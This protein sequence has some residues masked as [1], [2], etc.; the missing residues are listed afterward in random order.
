M[1]ATTGDRTLFLRF[2]VVTL[3]AVLH[4]AHDLSH[5]YSI[6]VSALTGAMVV[7][8]CAALTLGHLLTSRW[9]ARRWL[10]LALGALISASFGLAILVPH[11]ERWDW[12]GL[13]VA[14]GGVVVGFGVAGLWLLVFRLPV[15]IERARLRDME[16]ESLRSEAELSRMRAHLHPHF[17]LN[18][19]NA[20]AGLVTEDPVEARR[21]IAALGDLVHD[22]LEDGEEL[23]P[24][25]AEVAWLR[26]Y[27]EILEIRHR[28]LLSL[29]WELA[30]ET[31]TVLVPRLLLQPLI[32]N[33]VNHG[34][35]RRRH[36]GSVMV[37][38][39]VVTGRG[40]RFVIEDNGPGFGGEL[41]EGL[42]IDLV[43]R[44]LA[45]LCPGSSLRFEPTDTGT[46]ATV[47]ILRSP[48]G[49]G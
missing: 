44:R 41:V 2:S 13:V 24:F 45:M 12:P 38:S 21:L 8:E 3:V 37:R 39:E 29:R 22:A 36:G 43:R 15:F 30:E 10:G 20:I 18:T 25:A 16:T 35:L 32:E 33:A 1:S 34:V 49:C 46:R 9:G 48:G 26:R 23:R 28:G 40:S 19:L 14:A 17:F 42:G 27:A 6:W 7:G 4:T 11:S 31:L 5:G 47:E